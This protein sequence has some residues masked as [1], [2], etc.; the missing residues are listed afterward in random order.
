MFPQTEKGISASPERDDPG[1]QISLDLAAFP[2]GMVSD[3]LIPLL[4]ALE[5][6]GLYRLVILK[7]P[8]CPQETHYYTPVG[9]IP[10]LT[11]LYKKELIPKLRSPT[12]QR[13]TDKLGFIDLTLIMR[14]CS[15][16]KHLDY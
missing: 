9:T 16:R 7:P 6:P 8:R 15:H 5:V 13:S 12:G 1:S 11:F 10:P 14:R 2:A 3:K 4:L